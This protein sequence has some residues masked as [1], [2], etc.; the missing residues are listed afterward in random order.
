MIDDELKA[1]VM[2]NHFT[3]LGSVKI[4]LLLSH[5]KSAVD[6]LRSPIAD[7]AQL[8]GFGPKIVASWKEGLD[9]HS[10]EQD[11]ALVERYH[12]QLIPFTSPLYP[13]R[14]KQIPDFPL[15]LYVMG[16]LTP[17]DQKSIS[18]VGTRQPSLYGQEMAL[19]ISRDLGAQQ[20]TIVS[21]L[22][23]G[24]DTAAH[25]G[26][27]ESERGRTL[28]IL[29]SGLAN[30]YPR[31][32]SD[33]A[34]KICARGAIISEFP[35]NTAPNKQHF[36][37]R[38]RIVSGLSL[39]TFLVEAPGSSG[40]MQTAEKALEQNRPV[41]TLPGRADQVYYRGN[42]SLIKKGKAQLIEEASDIMEHFDHQINPSLFDM[43]VFTP[44]IKLNEEEKILLD[45]LP[46]YELSIEEIVK[47]MQWPVAKLNA[48]LMGLV[49][50]KVMKEFPGKIYKKAANFQIN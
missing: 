41:F 27:L 28:A 2:L 38:N 16:Q 34:K 15:I 6:A 18:I 12:A 22:A 20:Y 25:C 23:R 43:P 48:L 33:L 13:K 37:Q 4:R 49:M 32:N 36:P 14:L 44:C 26:A 47:Q 3:Y 1:L 39:G 5:F 50:K 21:G 10:W 30:I 9:S 29:G 8:P 24:I 11:L 17:S 40:A 45:C 42:H 31:E 19:K 7:I 46:D 35:M